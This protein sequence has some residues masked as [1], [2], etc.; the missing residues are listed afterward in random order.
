MTDFRDPE[1]AALTAVIRRAIQDGR[2]HDATLAE[3]IHDAGW[4]HVAEVEPSALCPSG[5]I[6][7][8]PNHPRT[9]P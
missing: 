6:D 1:V 3:A 4:R 2:V 7:V 5:T 8:S 9:E